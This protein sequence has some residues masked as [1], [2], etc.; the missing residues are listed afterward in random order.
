M[1]TKFSEMTGG[2]KAIYGIGL[3]VVLAVLAPLAAIAATTVT[4]LFTALIYGVGIFATVVMFPFINRFLK[5]MALKLMKAN[6]RMNPIETLELDLLKKKKSL[7]AF[8]KFVTEMAAGY[9][10]TKDE[11]QD[12]KKDYPDRDLS[13]EGTAVEKMG[14]AVELLRTKARGAGDKL[15]LYEEEVGFMKR[16]HAFAKRVGSAMTQLRNVEGVDS[17]DELLKDEA[18]GQV[19]NDVAFA[20]AELDSL[21]DQ[22]GTREVLQIAH[23]RSPETV[24]GTAFEIPHFFDN[25]KVPA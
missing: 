5:T 19:R 14:E 22:E 24:D 15:E 20:F 9:T 2:Q 12:L 11:F 6:A 21:L 3:L 16:N 17:L 13:K 4:S 1:I 23:Q 25:Q 10:V 18:I 7:Q 8:I